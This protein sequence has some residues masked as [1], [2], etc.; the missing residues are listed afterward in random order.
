M[1]DFPLQDD[2]VLMFHRIDDA[3]PFVVERP[4]IPKACVLHGHEKN[5]ALKRGPLARLAFGS[6]EVSERTPA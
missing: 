3:L 5:I 4:D 1:S 6:A 2:D